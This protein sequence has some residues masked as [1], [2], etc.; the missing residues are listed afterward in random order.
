MFKFKRK[1]WDLTI[2][3]NQSV[4]HTCLAASGAVLYSKLFFVPAKEEVNIVSELEHTNVY[5]NKQ[6][7]DLY[8]QALEKICLNPKLLKKVTLIYDQLIKNLEVASKNLLKECSEDNFQ[9]YLDCYTKLTAG[10]FLTAIFGR[11]ISVLLKD[12]LSNLYPNFN[13]EQIDIKVAELSYPEVNT[14]LTL[15]QVGLLKLVVKIKKQNILLNEL[16]T[17]KLSKEFN[18]LQEKFRAIPVNYSGDPWIEVDFLNQLKNILND[19]P[20][21]T[22]KDFEENH[23]TRIKTMRRQ[24]ALLPTEYLKKLCYGLQVCTTYNEK[25]KFAICN[26]ALA[27]RPLFILVAKKK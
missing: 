14:P 18:D 19:N 17:S 4:F 1:I 3:R 6:N 16:T 5:T 11:R 10:L 15:S 12:K 23:K 2:T 27:Y 26:A 22:L 21:K 20:E 8:T 13:S 24:I 9:K 7:L 25:R